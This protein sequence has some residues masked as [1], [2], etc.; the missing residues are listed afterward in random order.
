MK[1]FVLRSEDIRARCIAEIEKIALDGPLTE[2]LIRE[3]RRDRTLQTNSY[4]WAAIVEP[5][6]R[7]TG[8]SPHEMHQILLGDYFGWEQKKVLGH[9]L[10]LPRRTTTNPERLSQ[11][12]MSHFI[13]HCESVKAGVMG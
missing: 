4:Y 6:A 12:E 2:V 5:L 10:E 13:H 1:K 8:T 7:H 11:E 9:T 3:Y